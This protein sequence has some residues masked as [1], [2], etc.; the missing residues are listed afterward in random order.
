[1]SNL[2]TNLLSGTLIT[3]PN[4]NKEGKRPVL[5]RLLDSGEVLILRFH[6][7]TTLIKALEYNIQCGCGYVVH[8]SQGTIVSSSLQP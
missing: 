6:H 8:V 1:M 5:G 4:C 7:G 2:Q 3:C